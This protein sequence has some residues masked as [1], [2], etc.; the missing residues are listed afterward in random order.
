MN[1]HNGLLNE[2]QAAEYLGLSVKTLQGWRQQRKGPN[3]MKIFRNV[4]YSLQDIISFQ[5][6]CK[7]E[8]DKIVIGER[9]A[10]Q[11]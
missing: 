11:Q 2:K 4:R 6:N 7:I 9:H 3:Y 10:K 1:E 5:E 8:Q